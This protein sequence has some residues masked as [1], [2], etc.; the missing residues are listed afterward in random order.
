MTDWLAVGKFAICFFCRAVRK[1]KLQGLPV[2]QFGL[3]KEGAG[4]TSKGGT[5]NLMNKAPHPNAA[6]VFTNWLLSRE[7][8][9][10]FMKKVKVDEGRAEDSLRID[11]PKDEF[12][13]PDAQRKEGVAYIDVD[14]PE[15]RDMSPIFKLLKETLAKAAK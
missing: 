3:M 6:K 14:T 12:I 13:P 1:A 7:G 15:R 10:A 4:L 2:N 9:I 8:Q 5:I 11:I